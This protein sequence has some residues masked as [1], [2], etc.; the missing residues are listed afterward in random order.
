MHRHGSRNG[1]QNISLAK[2]SES[3][4]GPFDD[5]R[6]LEA[7]A[8][9]FL[10]ASDNVPAPSRCRGVGFALQVAVYTIAADHLAPN[11]GKQLD[12][13]GDGVAPDFGD[14]PLLELNAPSNCRL[15]EG[16]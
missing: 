5:Q 10:V 3:A 9:I 15:G 8:L 4:P 14:A 6:L 11:V 16:H 7:T 12:V 2:P 13:T 1:L